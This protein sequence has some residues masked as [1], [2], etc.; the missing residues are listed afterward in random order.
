MAHMER[1]RDVILKFQDALSGFGTA[2]KKPSLDG[3]YMSLVISPVKQ[4]KK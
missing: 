4:D 2:D 3:R 1:G